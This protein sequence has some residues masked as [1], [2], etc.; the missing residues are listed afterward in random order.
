[1]V[2]GFLIGGYQQLFVSAG[3]STEN[4]FIWRFILDSRKEERYVGITYS[5]YCHFNLTDIHTH[6]MEEEALSS[7]C[8]DQDSGCLKHVRLLVK[9]P[10]QA[11]RHLSTAKRICVS[12]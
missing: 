5:V 10:R 11:H 8:D 4:D 7:R 2:C 3:H 6:M 12:T 9:P 1:M